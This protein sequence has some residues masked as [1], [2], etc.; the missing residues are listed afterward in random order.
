MRVEFAVVELTAAPVANE[1]RQ[2]RSP[3]QSGIATHKQSCSGISKVSIW[4]QAPQ[5]ILPSHFVTSSLLSVTSDPDKS[6]RIQQTFDEFNES[7]LVYWDAYIELQNQLYD[8]L[9]AARDVTWLGATDSAKMSEINAAQRQLFS[10][11]PRRL[12]YVPLGQ[13]N[14]SMDYA[15]SKVNELLA[16]LFSEKESCKRLEAAIDILTEKANRTKQELQ[17]ES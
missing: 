15:L 14:R 16:K 9:K 5:P 12:D 17:S 4:A 1:F 13:I 10:T 2:E 3:S 6:K 11:M 8:S 7:W